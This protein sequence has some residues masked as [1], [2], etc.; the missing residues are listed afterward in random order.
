MS[1]TRRRIP[2]TIEAEALYRNDHTCCICR[3]WSKDVQRLLNGSER[4]APNPSAV[5][6]NRWR[7]TRSSSSPNCSRWPLRRPG[8]AEGDLR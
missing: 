1:P 7:Y 4:K 3:D 2:R 8:S 5:R 6:H